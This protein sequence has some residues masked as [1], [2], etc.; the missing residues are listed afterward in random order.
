MKKIEKLFFVIR[1]MLIARTTHSAASMDA[2]MLA[3]SE[4]SSSKLNNENNVLKMLVCV[5]TP[6]VPKTF[7]VRQWFPNFSGARTT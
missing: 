4:V 3:T 5:S 6:V 7:L 2:S 1:P